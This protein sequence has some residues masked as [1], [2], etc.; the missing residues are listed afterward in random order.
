M[1]N[2]R[3]DFYRGTEPISLD[4]YTTDL[5]AE[6]T[7]EFIRR[8][9]EDRFFVYVPFNA[10]HYPN[11]KNKPAGEPAIWQ[12]PDWAFAAYGYD[13][14][15]LHE[16]QRYRAVLTALDA[17]V[18]RIL[19]QLD[20]LE[21]S[22]NTIAIV[23]SDNG[24]FM[25]PG[26]GLEC[27]S[28]RPFKAGG[29]MLYEGG[30]RVPCLV[31]WPARLPAGTVCEAALSAMDLLPLVLTAAGVTLPA[32]RVLDGRNPLPALA[33]HAASPHEYLHFHYGSSDAIRWK[34]WKLY[35]RNGSSP[36]ELY[37]L[38]HDAGETSNRAA[39]HPDVVQ[40]LEREHARWMA[41]ASTGH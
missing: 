11:P 7:C 8:H 37:D 21:L 31:R 9:S 34:N 4:G 40:Q 38:S 23:L 22:E 17:G 36:W 26:R 10:A 35:R 3:H 27:A 41:E 13:P 30:I 5:L 28:N 2:G 29:T 24:A 33:G 18:G 16:R 12:A 39:A 20:A 19:D 1:Y 14:E 32:D 15:T 25:I 6:A